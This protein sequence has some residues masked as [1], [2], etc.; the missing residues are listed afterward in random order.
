MV[1]KLGR[2][3]YTCYICGMQIE[4]YRPVRFVKQLYG[5]GNYKQYADIRRY[6]F[7][8]N[9]YETLKKG[10]DKWKRK[11]REGV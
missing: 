10:L 9:C 11:K 1:K 8:D 6:D 5:Y 3:I 2:K 4:Q 7:C